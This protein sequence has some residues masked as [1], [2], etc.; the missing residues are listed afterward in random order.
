MR[1]RWRCAVIL[2]GLGVL[3][4]FTL[5]SVLVPGDAVVPGRDAV[6]MYVWEF[7]TRA[8]L[9]AGSLPFWNPFHFAGTPHLA[10]VQRTILYPAALFI[11][12]LP[13]EDFLSWMAALH[14][15]IAGA[16][17]LFLARV[18]GLSWLA[19][20]A[21]AVAGMLGG[22]TAARLHNGHLLP[23]YS[24]SWLPWS[25]GLAIVSVRRA[26]VAPHPA[27]VVVL[28]LQFLAGFIQSSIYLAAVICLYYL[29]CAI[30]RDST[31]RTAPRRVV[32]Q[33]MVA[34]LL[35]IGLAAFQLLPTARL[36]ANAGRWYGIPYEKAIEG[37][38]TAHNLVSFFFPFFGVVSDQPHRD[39]TEAVAYVGWVLTAMVPLA[40]LDRQRRR[41]VVFFGLLTCIAVA[42]VIV[43]LPF[44]RLHHALFPAFRVPGRILF[45]AALSLAVLG[46]IGL[47]QLV[48][49]ATARRWR[50]L[51]AGLLPGVV[52]I[53]VCAAV[54]R[55]ADSTFHPVPPVPA[56]PWLP[57]LVLIGIALAG[58]AAAYQ[59]PSIARAICVLFVAAEMTAF[60]TGAV[61]PVSIE[62]T[63]SLRGW[64]GEPRPG[65]AIS[66]CESRV[67]AGEMLR[68][69]Q[70]SLDGHAGGI[71]L[72]DYADWVAITVTGNPLVRDGISRGIDSDGLLPAR[73]DLIDG[74]DVTVIYSC[75]PLDA[76]SL[77]LVSQGNGVYV[78]RNESARP[79][80]HWTCGGVLT[81]RM[82]A[83][84][85]IVGSRFGPDG[86]LQPRAYI[87][88]RWVPDLKSDARAR[89]ERRYGLADGVA[90][91]ERTWRYSLEDSSPTTVLALVGDS[92]VE[93]THG[94]DRLTG[95][96]MQSTA[97]TDLAV[98]RDGGEMLTGTTP[99]A[100]TGSVDVTM[101]DQFDGRVIA[102]VD[103]P[104]AGYVVLSEPFYPE[105]KAFIDG[106]AVA[107]LKANL[108]F[109]A[110]PV[111]AGMHTLELRYVP[112]S[113]RLGI[114]VS[115]ATVMAWA[116]S[117][118]LEGKFR[119]MKKGRARRRG[120]RFGP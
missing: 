56:W 98:V 97:V 6:E 59:R 93:D 102:A 57:A 10:D 67:G 38:W 115:V 44:Y 2:V 37:G 103:S 60:T 46:G 74:A 34:G 39:L 85:Q 3:V 90:L 41:V 32:I 4:L 91:D 53:V 52:A 72:G 49:L 24:A 110:V 25:L 86:R 48:T 108:A 11:R 109:T 66:T 31:D 75:E 22:V 69:R 33:L 79:R 83:E 87:N 107:A 8:A 63:D 68:N 65:R 14:L 21:T 20:A 84:A 40:F 92:A 120:P 43:D 7:Y 116:A 61:A 118:V 50:S 114:A 29:Y 12:W 1:S 9:S 19:S 73:R 95:S 62:S 28:V 100:A 15:W 82:S 13:L 70:P 71:T 51:A 42:L 111:P 81:T 80:A 89:V 23:L 106:S 96:V 112:E 27:L 30:W 45:V 117:L 36:I 18:I 88:V 16:G 58:V 104:V 55:G 26:T 54:V 119:R 47:D 94:V 5:R 78:Y 64:M 105:R 17:C 101:Q 77:S 76:P 35:A 99:C 113:F